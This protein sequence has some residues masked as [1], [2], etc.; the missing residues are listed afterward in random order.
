MAWLADART[1]L[2]YVP[3]LP[4]SVVNEYLMP[5]ERVVTAV[6][7]HPISI[8]KAVLI[9]LGGSIV[10]A[11]L[12]GEGASAV[13]WL[14][15]AALVIWQG[16]KIATWWRKYFAVTEN[17]LMLITSLIDTDVGMMPLAKVTD[18]RMRQS[19]FGRL[20]GYGE[21]IVESAGQE[22][23]LSRVRYVPY[24]TQMYQEI[25]SLIFPRKPAP[26]GSSGS[27]GSSGPPGPQGPPGPPGPPQGPARG[28]GP[29][30]DRP[31]PPG[32]GWPWAGP[33]QVPPDQAPPDRPG[34][35]PGFLSRPGGTAA[36][37][38]ARVQAGHI[39]SDWPGRGDWSSLPGGGKWTRSVNARAVGPCAR[40]SRIASSA[41]LVPGMCPRGT[42]HSAV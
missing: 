24:P 26:G 41:S 16:W 27:P 36:A 30:P 23:A 19:T 28:Q 1:R 8:I 5:T 39:Q 17:R 33:D 25:L 9:I 37:V 42:H 7:M 15:W 38:P 21:F 32:P 18:M 4:S 11:I 22:Q 6:R 40:S 12:L 3:Q 31:R 14:L 29:P 20:L 13:I 35:D 10:T 34:D 2:V